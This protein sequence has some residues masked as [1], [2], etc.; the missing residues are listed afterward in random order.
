MQFFFVLFF[1]N[2]TVYVILARRPVSG[3]VLQDSEAHEIKMRTDRTPG[4][5]RKR[6]RQNHG[7]SSSSSSSCLPGTAGWCSLKPVR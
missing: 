7:R 4:K 6:R 3:F 5:R 1:F 2:K